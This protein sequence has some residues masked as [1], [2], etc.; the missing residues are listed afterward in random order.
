VIATFLLDT[1]GAALRLPDRVLDQSL[2]RHLGQPM[3]GHTDPVGV[4]T[5]RVMVIGGL[6]VCVIGLTR[7]D[8][9]R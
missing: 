8:V 1:L 7:R 2:Y 5:A 6:T 4:A 3:A 9:G